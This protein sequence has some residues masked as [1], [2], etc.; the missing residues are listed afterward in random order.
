MD[1]VV[2]NAPLLITEEFID[3]NKIDLVVHGDD[4]RQAYEEQHKIPR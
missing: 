2:E 4:I 1:E 3:K